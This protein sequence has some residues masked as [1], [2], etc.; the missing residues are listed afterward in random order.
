MPEYD[1]AA[2]NALT[3]VLNK[4]LGTDG[5]VYDPNA[6]KSDT[7]S[8][9]KSTNATYTKSEASS[10]E[11]SDTES[12]TPSEVSIASVT[13]CSGGIIFD[14]RAKIFRTRDKVLWL[15]FVEAFSPDSSGL[16]PQFRSGDAFKISNI[17]GEGTK[18]VRKIG[19]TD[20]LL[21]YSKTSTGG[22]NLHKGGVKDSTIGPN[23]F[24]AVYL[25][26]DVYE[27]I[28]NALY[29]DLWYNEDSN[30]LDLIFWSNVLQSDVSSEQGDLLY[31]KTWTP[32]NTD[33]SVVP[34]LQRILFHSIGSYKSVV[35]TLG[36]TS[37]PMG[38]FLFSKP[39]P[40]LNPGDEMPV[41]DVNTSNNRFIEF[42]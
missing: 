9:D 3:N 11:S 26:N 14:K 8:N 28:K 29:F 21:Y 35:A 7:K 22:F 1:E 23:V 5:D 27:P 32:L 40:I 37:Y 38:M 24:W 16:P 13:S 2:D 6:G 17:R 42:T 41:L 36:T 15:F 4:V 10:E 19:D 18:T 12:D 31:D 33:G 30:I 39:I 20:S 34:D 25:D